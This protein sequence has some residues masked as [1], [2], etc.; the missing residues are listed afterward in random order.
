VTNKKISGQHP[1]RGITC[2]SGLL[3]IV[4]S[5][6]YDEKLGV[7]KPHFPDFL[8]PAQILRYST[9]RPSRY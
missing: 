2:L 6:I 5:M 9:N 7:L 3:L 4:G 8:V 1:T